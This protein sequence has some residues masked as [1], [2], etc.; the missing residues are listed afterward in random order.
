MSE[1]SAIAI[2]HQ[3]PRQAMLV[4][5]GRLELRDY[6]PPR[7]GPGELLIEVRCALSCGTDLKTFRRGHPIWKLPTPFGHEFSGV[8]VEAGAGVKSFKAGDE[9]MAAPTAP[10]GICFYCQ[11][12]QENLCA[13]AMDKMV[14]GAYADLLLLPAHVVARNTFIKPVGLPFEEAALL[15]PLSCVIHAQ[16]MAHPQKSESVLII[17]G[18]AFGLMHMLGLKASGVREVAVL[19]RGAQRLKW[20]AEMGADE[21]IDA[22]GDGAIAEVARLNGGFGP[23][24]VIECTGQVQGW[25]DALARVRRGGRVV[26]FGGCPSGTKLSVDTRRMHYDNLTLIAPFHSRPRDVR[27][28]FELLAARTAGFGAIVNARRSL[29]ELAEVFA[30]LERGEVL[31]CAVIP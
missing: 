27:R 18:G 22:R 11:H 4:E 16:E 14:M 8:V 31:K 24:L 21:V 17:G 5:L 30:M 23:D 28:A 26:F 15:E 6:T 1:L 20:A 10:C 9:V 19:G 3:Q 25:E 12:G 29:S 7:P 13:L 2:G